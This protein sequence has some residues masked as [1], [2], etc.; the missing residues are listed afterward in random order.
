MPSTSE[1]ILSANTATDGS[2]VTTVVGDAYK[3]DGYYGRSDGFHT[4]QYDMSGLTGDIIIQATLATSP[5]DDDWFDIH[6]YTAAQE[7]SVKYTNI[8][9]N[10]V[11]LR[12]KLVIT[13]GTVN[14]IRLN[15]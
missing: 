12:A 8:T 15:H 11:F 5:T 6:T 14:S 3:G 2:T 9:G 10:F 7:T 13:D 1:T 4:I